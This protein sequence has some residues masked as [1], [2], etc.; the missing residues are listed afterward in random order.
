MDHH[1]YK[2]DQRGRLLWKYKARGW[3]KASPVIDE[4]GRVYFGSYDRHVYAVSS[5]GRP[6][7]QF[8]GKAQFTSSAAID[9]AGNLYCG[10]TSGT[11]YA[12]DRDGKLILAIQEPRFHHRRPDHP[13]RQESSWPGAST[14]SCWLSAPG[15]RCRKRPGGQSTSA[16]SPIRGSTNSS[17]TADLL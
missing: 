12:L 3:I 5:D 7:W 17:T 11:V 9:E 14:A 15:S 6:L 2:L 16:I 10:D 1:L 13:A 8:L 4:K